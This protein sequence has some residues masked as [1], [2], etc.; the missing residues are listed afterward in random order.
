VNGSFA[1]KAGKHILC[2]KPCGTTATEV[3]A[4]LDACKASN[5]QFMDGVMFMHSKRLPL[6]RQVLDDGTSVGDIRR[7]VS[8]FTFAASD[9][10][11]RNN[12]RVSSELEPLG[13]LGDLGWYNVRFSLWAM[14]YQMPASERPNDRGRRNGESPVPMEFSG[15]LFF[16]NGVSAV[17]L[18]PH[19]TAA[20]GALSARGSLT[21]PDFVLPYFGCEARSRRTR[22]SSTC[23]AVISLGGHPRRHAVSRP[24]M[25]NR[26]R[27]TT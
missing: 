19:G 8:Q 14:K 24:A 17:L 10:F 5:V 6:L 4:M 11:Q 12:I 26:M 15:E 18:I 27:R 25:E 13:C 22:R 23:R 9:D 21:V 20:M 7:I 3:Q 2:E 16:A 1:G